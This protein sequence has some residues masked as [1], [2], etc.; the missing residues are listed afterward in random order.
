MQLK[1]L[2]LGKEYPITGEIA[3][4]KEIEQI[5]IDALKQSFPDNIRPVLRD[6]HPKHHGCVRAEFII[7]EGIPQ[8]LK[9]GIFK[10]PRTFTA[11]IRFSNNKAVDD[12]KK[13]VRGMAIKL[14]GV[15]GEKLLERQKQE[16]TQDLLLINHP[17]FF[18]K[19]VQDYVE[20]FRARQLAKGN[21]PLKFFFLNPNPFKWHLREFIIGMVM[22]N[23]KVNSPLVIQ[24]WSSTPYKLGDRA[25]KFTAVPS[26]Q[27]P[28][29]A[30]IQT[31]DYL[32]QAMIEHLNHQDASFDFLI[33]LQTDPQKMPIEDPRIEWKS[34]FQ[35][36]ATI[37]IPRQ[38]FTVPQQMEFCE[39][40]SFTPWHSLPEH[41]PLGGVN[42]ARK[43]VYEALAELRHNLNNIVVKEP[44]EE[45]FLTLWNKLM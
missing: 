35:K 32:R 45:D 1:K 20:F 22:L 5:S 3:G 7:D 23:K 6:A 2:E 44:T 25:I 34:P 17:V 37:K 27:N 36:V 29:P 21:L 43:Q 4:I 39:N 24:Y 33:Q 38:Q 41:Q 15:E 13:D 28:T 30:V 14:F 42:R 10:H 31:P 11:A 26:S 18:I 12:T 8:E 40:L 19:D 16:K 9:A